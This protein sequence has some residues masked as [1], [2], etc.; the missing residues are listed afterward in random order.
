MSI[1]EE[2]LRSL[3]NEVN[4]PPTPFSKMN[5]KLGVPKVAD[6]DK[7]TSLML[8]GTRGRGYAGQVE[9]EYDRINLDIYIQQD[10]SIRSEAT[11]TPDTL[12]T[13]I[14]LT[15]SLWLEADDFTDIEVPTV[16]IGES[17][18]IR[19]KLKA[20]SLGWYSEGSGDYEINYIYGRPFIDVVVA[21]KAVGEIVEVV[22]QGMVS[23]RMLLWGVDFT[24]IAPALKVNPTTLS[25]SDPTSV[26]N[27]AAF[28]GVSEWEPGVITDHPTAEI[29][30]SNQSFDR[31]T[32]QRN[33][34][35]SSV[36]GPLYFHYNLL[37]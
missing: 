14:N 30:D 2:K 15:H 35:S 24:S 31:V 3:L 29:E 9:V 33:L 4:Y 7:N 27:A 16:S 21:K 36:V 19:L 18:A 22:E 10:Y 28:Y 8:T 17:G 12:L 11:L 13:H 1:T 20:D 26:I 32:I 5:L 23:A 25:Y 6:S 34:V 37:D